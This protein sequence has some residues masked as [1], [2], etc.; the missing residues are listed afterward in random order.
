MVAEF[1]SDLIRMRT[2]EGMKVAR[3]KGRLRGKQ[4]KLSPTQEAHLVSLYAAGE[5]TI[6]ELED[7]SQS[8]ARRSTARSLAV[9]PARQPD[10][11]STGIL[12]RGLAGHFVPMF[13]AGRTGIDASADAEGVDD[14]RLKLDDGTPS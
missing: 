7:C 9:T 13:L 10:S 14:V 12:A 4:P 3:A 11:P 6:G 2:R 8:H 1:E 5:H